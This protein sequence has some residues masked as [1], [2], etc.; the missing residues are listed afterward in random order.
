MSIRRAVV[1]AAV[2]AT[3]IGTGVGV[4]S[5]THPRIRP[6][7]EF[8]G[9]VNGSTGGHQPAVVKVACPSPDPNQRTHPLP[10]QTLAV[11][12]PAASGGTVGNTGPDATHITAVFGIPPSSTATGGLATF[13]HFGHAKPIPTSIS[14]PCSGTGYITFLPFPRVPGETVPFVVPI[15]FANIAG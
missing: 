12:I 13:K 2:V 8:V 9:L 10:H 14:V 15:E 5:A 1:F 11:S 7:E 4:A 3:T 6:N